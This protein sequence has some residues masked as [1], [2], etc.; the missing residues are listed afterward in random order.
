MTLTT[1]TK[2]LLGFLA[3][4]G[5]TVIVFA[6]T[7]SGERNEGFQPTEEFRLEPWIDIP[8]PLDFN[9]AV[10][11]LLIAALLT[12]IATVYIANRMAARPNRVQTA[13]ETLYLLMRDNIAR[14][15]MDDE[16]ARKWFPFV[17]TLFLFIWF[18]NLIGYLPLPVNDAHP[19]DVFGLE[20]PAFAIYA[21]TANIS[22]PLA[23][24]L[25]VW[26]AY[27]IEGLRAQ[28]VGGYLKSWIPAGTP[29]PLKPMLF[30]IEVISHFVRIV[31]LSVRL[32]ANILA[33]HLLILFM[34]GGLAVILGLSALGVVTLPVAIVFFVFEVGLIATLQAFI[35][36]T[37]TAIYLGGATS[38][39]H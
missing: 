7:G 1:R 20:I 8:G 27:H 36:A 11:Y 18:S 30:G 25:M 5:L 16:M 37:L 33:G 39:H 10:M 13:V 31:S 15:N 24:T 3:L 6:L 17:G 19:I 2:V 32:F 21:A 38:E 14:G 4:V 35:F 26:F 23:L 12:A 34:A 9:K 28:G 22:V 29:G